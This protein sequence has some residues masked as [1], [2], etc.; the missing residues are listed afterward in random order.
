MKT[1][2]HRSFDNDARLRVRFS[3]SDTSN[4]ARSPAGYITNTCETEFSAQTAVSSGSKLFLTLTDAF[5]LRD[6]RER[7]R[8]FAPRPFNIALG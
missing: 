4:L 8:Q 6:Q 1:R 7:Q 3:G 5:C 2:T